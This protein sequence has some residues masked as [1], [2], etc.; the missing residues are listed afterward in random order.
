MSYQILESDEGTANRVAESAL[1]RGIRFLQAFSS[2]T[3]ALPA[4]QLT[5]ATAL[6]KPSLHSTWL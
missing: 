4:R 5:E 6:P 1:A 3:T 2:E